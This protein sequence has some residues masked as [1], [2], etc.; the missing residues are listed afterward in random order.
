MDFGMIAYVIP[1]RRHPKTY[2]KKPLM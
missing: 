2:N 1:L